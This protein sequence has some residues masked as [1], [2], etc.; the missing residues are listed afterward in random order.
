[1]SEENSLKDNVADW[2][3]NEGYPFEMRVAK[4]F[5]KYRYQVTQSS[6]YKDPF[7]E[8][9]RELDVVATKRPK[10]LKQNIRFKFF[11][12]CKSSI[13]KPWI[14][15]TSPHNHPSSP[16]LNVAITPHTGTLNEFMWE[17][18]K[19]VKFKAQLELF[20]IPHEAGHSVVQSFN[21]GKDSAYE[22]V[23]QVI[24]AVKAN[25]DNEDEGRFGLDMI[26]YPLIV[27]DEKLFEC[28]LDSSNEPVLTEV[29]R[30]TLVWYDDILG[31][32]FT[33]V[34]IVTEEELSNL[35]ETVEE[36]LPEV[37]Q[38]YITHQKQKREN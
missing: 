36:E 5:S 24:N 9:S 16:G 15:F 28:K 1:M 11:V 14:I 33:I 25:I 13:D 4:E 27:T 19:K 26:A 23:N 2:L 22:S 7:T 18:S 21:T 37:F 32:P 35:L 8:K 29:K 31:T 3:N 17:L 12:E 30:S 20:R 38:E 10:D 34:N 6:Y